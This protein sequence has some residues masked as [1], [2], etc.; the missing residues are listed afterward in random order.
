MISVPTV[1][2]VTPTAIGHALSVELISMNILVATSASIFQSAKLLY[3]IFH[4]TT[5][6]RC[7][8]MFGNQRIRRLIMI[9]SNAFPVACVVTG[10]TGLI[11]IVFRG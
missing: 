3:L 9:K 4:V 5:S 10:C 1:G 11:W 6:T 8:L 2:L 7:C